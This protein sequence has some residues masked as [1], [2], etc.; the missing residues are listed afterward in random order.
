MAV[1]SHNKLST[2]RHMC[3]FDPPAGHMPPICS[4]NEDIPV[5]TSSYARLWRKDVVFSIGPMDNPWGRWDFCDIYGILVTD[6]F[7]SQ[8]WGERFVIFDHPDFL[9]FL[10]NLVGIQNWEATLNISALDPLLRTGQS[11]GWCHLCGLSGLRV[12]LSS[13]TRCEVGQLAV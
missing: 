7:P 3:F 8:V 10:F 13:S 4:S 6:S 11:C 9:F 2:T 5:V 12:F 1:I